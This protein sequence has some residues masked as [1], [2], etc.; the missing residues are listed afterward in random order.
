M[1][2]SRHVIDFVG[3]VD[4]NILQCALGQYKIVISSIFGYCSRGFKTTREIYNVKNKL[5]IHAGL[6]DSRYMLKPVFW[7]QLWIARQ[8]LF[9]GSV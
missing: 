2:K 5:F 3:L 7:I 1:Y 9:K 6:G 8:L 4:K